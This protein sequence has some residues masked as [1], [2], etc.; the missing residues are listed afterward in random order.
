MMKKVLIV[1]VA[2]LLTMGTMAQNS[3]KG[4]V[5]YKLESAGETAFQIPEEQS[6][7]EVKVYENQAMMGQTIQSGKTIT[8][9]IDYGM[10]IQYLLSQDIELET[11]TGDGKVMT[12]QT[13]DQGTID[14]LT[15]PATKG[16]YFEYVKGE[17]QEIAGWTANKAILHVFNDEGKDM[18][19][20]FWYTPEIGPTPNFLF[21]G[22]AGMPLKF[23]MPAG[24]GRAIAYTAI[25][26]KK[27]KVKEADMLLPAGFKEVTDEEHAL[28][29]RELQEALELLE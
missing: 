23:T 15:I 9:C 5:K 8:S 12:K 14:S 13:V 20:E 16:I 6:I 1:A 18:P 28:I 17:T 26:I 21:N 3:F 7:V 27:G 11:Y 2:M 19:I 25:E 22:I 4:I 29:A 24:E 10:Y